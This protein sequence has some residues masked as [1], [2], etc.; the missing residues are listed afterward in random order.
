MPKK[1]LFLIGPFESLN[2]RKDSSL[3][4][5]HT[6][7]EEGAEV[8]ILEEEDF[9]LTPHLPKQRLMVK[10]FESKLFDQEYYMEDFKLGASFSV[11]LDSSWLVHM[12]VDPPLDSRYIRYLWMLDYLRA[13]GVQVTNSPR[14]I[15]AYNEKLSPY[16]FP[17]KTVPSFYG[18]NLE[19]IKDFLKTVPTDDIVVKPM[20]SFSGIGVEKLPLKE[21]GKKRIL[22]HIKK[23]GEAVI[24]QPFLEKV[25]EG[26]LRAIFL[27]AKLL[28]AIKKY[29]QKGSFLANIAQGAKFEK[30]NL[31]TEVLRS[32]EILAESLFK[33]GIDLIA[34]DICDQE[35][36]EVNI[37]CPGL[38]NEVS[39]ALGKNL[40]LD[41]AEYF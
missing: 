12:R 10:P 1:H 22:S 7:K 34:F 8:F 4:L 31:E 35:I 5:A 16:F 33:D 13:K 37:T 30:I 28:G 18:E 17:V 25:L 36:T 24:V 32:C 9:Y 38:I 40:A 26:E 11:E 20:D 14:G 15:M 6:M 39:Q 2:I 3:F 23:R 21:W 27:G 41:Y 29:P 19:G